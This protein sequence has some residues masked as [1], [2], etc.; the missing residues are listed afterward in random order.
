MSDKPRLYRF[1]FGHIVGAGAVT[2]VLYGGTYL[3]GYVIPLPFGAALW[4]AMAVLMG[5]IGATDPLA[6]RFPKP[7]PGK[8]QYTMSRPFDGL[9]QWEVRLSHQSDGPRRPF[10]E[11]GAY[12]GLRRVAAET[13]RY[14]RGLD[15]D[16]HPDQCR[17]LLGDDL[18]TLLVLPPPRLPDRE[19]LDEYTSRLERI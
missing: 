1:R 11:S 16:E 10:P 9:A 4:A 12:R 5:F 2:A 6:H 18:Y 13:L 7:R 19:L 8:R 17:E 14:R 3:A 15:L